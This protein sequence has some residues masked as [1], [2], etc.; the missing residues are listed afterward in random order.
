MATSPTERLLALA[1]KRG[2]FERKTFPPKEFH[3]FTSP[4][5]TGKGSSSAPLGGFTFFLM[6]T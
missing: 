1:A 4:G 5:S 3:E 2:S 6:R